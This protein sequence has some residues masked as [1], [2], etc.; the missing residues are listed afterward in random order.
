MSVYSVFHITP[1]SVAEQQLI[2]TGKEREKAICA[3]QCN[4]IQNGT[5][6]IQK[7]VT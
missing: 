2:A 3:K 6:S 5:R 4:R 1:I 7:D